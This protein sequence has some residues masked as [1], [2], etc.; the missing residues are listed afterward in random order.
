MVTL[1][2]VAREA[3]LRE[4]FR[5]VKAN[6]GAPGPDRQTIAMVEEHLEELLVKLS[7]SLLEET[8]EPGLIRRKWLPKPGGGERGLG[9]P[10]VVDRIVG[11]ALDQVLGPLYEPTFHPNSHGFITGRSCHTAIR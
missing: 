11:Q 3:N 6:K 10:D 2:E 9:I 5:R 1:E 8:Y 4:A 7:R